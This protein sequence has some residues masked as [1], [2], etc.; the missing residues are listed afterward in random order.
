MVEPRIVGV[1]E[2]VE[3]PHSLLPMRKAFKGTFIVAGGYNRE[4]GNKAVSSGYADLVAYGR[5][6]LANPDLPQ[7]FEL[8]APLNNYN[9]STF[10]TPD[11]VVGYTDYPF[12]C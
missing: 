9:S 4:E 5:I 1:G 12:L 8:D 11:P 7:R 2:M 6:F 10:Y 3:T